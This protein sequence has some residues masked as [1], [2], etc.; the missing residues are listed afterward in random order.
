MNLWIVK[1]GAMGVFLVGVYLWGHHMG[2]K[3][4]QDDWDSRKAKDALAQTKLVEH[5]AEEVAEIN[6]KNDQNNNEVSNNYQKAID[7]NSKKYEAAIVAARSHG[8]RLPASVCSATRT[9][10]TA[11]TTGA[12][13]TPTGTVALPDTTTENL[14]ALVKRADEV[15]EQARACQNWISLN[16]F[17]P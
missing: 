5:H 14:L 10:E 4:V 1:I 2:A 15:T 11:S 7:E 16:G 9:T 8:L 6:R 12:N 13:E 3:A 17:S